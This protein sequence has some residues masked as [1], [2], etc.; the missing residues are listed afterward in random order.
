MTDLSSLIERVEKLTGADREVD[1]LVALAF[2]ETFLKRHI[3]DFERCHSSRL[4]RGGGIA[5][6]RDGEPGW[7]IVADGDIPPLSA[8]LDAAVAFTEA[9][10]PGWWLELSGDREVGFLASVEGP[11]AGDPCGGSGQKR[12]P[13][14]ALALILAALRA[15][16]AKERDHG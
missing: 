13:T 4:I 15:L 9:T 12:K 6:H 14:L 1:H 11:K 3:F 16:Q 10:L 2:P 8:S 7:C 5:Y